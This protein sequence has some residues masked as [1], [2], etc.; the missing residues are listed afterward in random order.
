MPE[1][2]NNFEHESVTAENKE[3]FVAANSKYATEQDAVVGG[4]NAQKLIGKP[5][6]PKSM[7]EFT[8][9]NARAEFR[10]GSLKL[11][12]SVD[13]VESLAD[14]NMK[15][16]Q[17]EGADFSEDFANSFKAFAV[18]KKWPKSM[19]QEGAE[20]YNVAM[21]KAT[22]A[23]LAKQEADGIALAKSTN[24]ALAKHFGSEE[25]VVKQTELF[26][27]AMKNDVGL[28][29]EEV[30]ELAD[31]LSLS[32][33]TKHPALARVMLKH[34]APLADEGSTETGSG[35]G[36]AENKG[37]TQTPYEAKKARWPKSPSTWG[38]ESDTWETQ[39]IETKRMFGFGKAEKK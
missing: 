7:E 9:D 31:D 18:E 10:A 3:A 35:T 26:V 38:A 14:V 13:S 23:F 21:A 8:D 1:W 6:L 5:R 19:V 32:K 28:T 12:G 37:L 36:T 15:L 2:L 25:E 27:R 29:P 20:F 22:E 4:Y 30:E 24:E 16:G 33:L 39:T 11:L 17:A 34:F